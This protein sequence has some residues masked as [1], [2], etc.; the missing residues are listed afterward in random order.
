MKTSVCHRSEAADTKEVQAAGPS[1]S[2][3]V[4][5]AAGGASGDALPRSGRPSESYW[6]SRNDAAAGAHTAASPYISPAGVL[7]QPVLDNDFLHH[8]P[9]NLAHSCCRL[10]GNC[11]SFSPACTAKLTLIPSADAIFG[12]ALARLTTSGDY[13]SVAN[14]A[15]GL[16]SPDPGS[17]HL[18]PSLSRNLTSPSSDP[19]PGGPRRSSCLPHSE[20]GALAH[21]TSYGSTQSERPMLRH[22]SS[23]G[24][25]AASRRP[26]G[27]EDMQQIMQSQPPAS[28]GFW[29]GYGTYDYADGTNLLDTL[30]EPPPPAMCG[31]DVED[32][33][34]PFCCKPPEVAC[35][36]PEHQ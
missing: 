9:G 36:T 11:I 2:E 21:N 19:Q 20:S 7:L 28:P 29:V 10:L 23:Q 22:N 18:N 3:G 25:T 12:G 8:I 15:A 14:L 35:F 32:P 27:A 6:D 5:P 17:A 4:K 1:H 16:E 24:S 30:P 26:S 33:L 13:R 34:R 31:P